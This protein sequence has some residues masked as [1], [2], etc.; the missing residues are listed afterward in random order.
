MIADFAL[1]S[2]EATPGA[3]FL[4]I[5]GARADGHD[6]AEEAIAR[7]AVAALVERRIGVP[8]LLAADL[9]EALARFGRSVRDEFA[10]PVVGITGSNGKT[11]TKE[12]AA[13]ALTP[14]GPVLKSAGN[15]NTEYTSPLAW[16][17]LEPEHRAATIEMAMR[18][19]GQIAHLRSISKPTVSV[20]TMIGSA[21]VEMVGSREGIA[22]AKS[23]IVRADELAPD[24]EHAI[25]W[26]ED[27]FYGYLRSACAPSTRVLTFGFGPDADAHVVGYRAV[28]WSRCVVRLRV[29]GVGVEAELPTVGRHQALNA[30]AALLAAWACGVDPTRAAEALACS[31]LPP[32]RLEPISL[33]EATVLVD[34]YN[35]SPDS[36]IAAVR[37]LAE[38]P[39][40]GRRIA[41][42][43]EMLE[44]GAFAESGHRQVGRALAEAD[45]DHVVLIGGFTDFCA[46]EAIRTG[47]PEDR[48]TR[49]RDLDDVT[50][51]LSSLGPGDL[52]LLKASRALG[53]E[54]A[55]GPLRGATA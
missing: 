39:C 35:A 33:G 14:L 31:K 18:G 3:L 36:A 45:L 52:V 21:H 17:E 41:V 28:D 15:R 7:G 40:T 51:F 55:L 53:L 46:S 49:A 2:R 29:M 48:L 26:L 27:D 19:F 23:E 6:H 11:A 13:A 16:A 32:M 30:A 1:D 5:R 22:R 12:F 34:T 38:L 37:T 8:G 24:P 43:G 44:L 47:F 42:I 10:G 9:V 20:I 54:R 25:L 50:R 4:A